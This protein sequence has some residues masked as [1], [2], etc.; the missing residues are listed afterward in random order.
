MT[1][2]LRFRSVFGGPSIPLTYFE[3]LS[4]IKWQLRNVEFQ[5]DFDLFVIVGGDITTVTDPTGVRSPRVFLARR[6]IT[7]QIQMNSA[8]VLGDSDPRGF[9]RQTIHAA[10]TELIARIAARDADFD[11]DVERQKVAFLVG[12]AL[13]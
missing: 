8:D 1:H 13:G 12:E 11:V 5:Y 6:T 3:E 7:A 2:R 4:R 9:L 10:V